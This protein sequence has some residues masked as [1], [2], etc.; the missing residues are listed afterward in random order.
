VPTLQPGDIVVLDHLG[1]HKVD[2]IEQAIESTG[3]AVEYLPPYSPD[4]SPIESAWSKA[5]ELLRSIAARTADALRAGV[6]KALEAVTQ[7]DVRGWFDHCG[8]CI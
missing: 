8:Y 1:V 4:L 2:G 6:K 5:K 3:A 7:L